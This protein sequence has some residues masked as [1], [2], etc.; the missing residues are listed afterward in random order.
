MYRGILLPEGLGVFLKRTVSSTDG[1][2]EIHRAD[3]SVDPSQ[4]R[5]GPPL[6]VAQDSSCR[7][8][9]VA[10]TGSPPIRTF[11][12]TETCGRVT[13]ILHYKTFSTVYILG[14]RPV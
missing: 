14:M 7:R 10:K 12:L 3:K 13:K 1:M 9:K 4:I 6:N 5:N 8:Q 11:S 2:V